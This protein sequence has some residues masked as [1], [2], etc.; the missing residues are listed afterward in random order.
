[1]ETIII[2]AGACILYVSLVSYC[3][4]KCRGSNYRDPF[5]DE[6]NYYTQTV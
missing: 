5:K 6:D 1:M 2:F 3:A 4:Y